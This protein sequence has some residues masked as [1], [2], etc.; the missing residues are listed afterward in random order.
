MTTFYHFF[1][2]NRGKPDAEVWELTA[3]ANFGAQKTC[4]HGLDMV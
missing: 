4:F 1:G 3:P 2:E